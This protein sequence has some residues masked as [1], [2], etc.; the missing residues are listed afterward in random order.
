MQDV[1]SLVNGDF[2][3][4]KEVNKQINSL[5][6]DSVSK[7][8]EI[9]IIEKFVLK[10][11][12]YTN[13]WEQWLNIDH[14][15]DADTVWQTKKED[16]DGQAIFAASILASRGFEKVEIVGNYQHIWVVVDDIEI[17]YPQKE[18]NIGSGE[19]V[20]Q[21]SFPSLSVVQSTLYFFISIFPA[22]RL[23]L[24]LIASIIIL[25]YP[26]KKWRIQILTFSVIL[27]MYGALYLTAIYKVNSIALMLILLVVKLLAFIY[28]FMKSKD[29]YKRSLFS[30]FNQDKFIGG[31]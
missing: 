23:I 5:I 8:E 25:S 30:G 2:R 3:A 14:W 9:N 28:L 29:D 4:K 10:N 12:E 16:C 11:I 15:P 27:F 31:N 21:Y 26:G 17:L 24:L 22:Y 1:S 19:G 18:K 13:D 7:K 6:K 20:G